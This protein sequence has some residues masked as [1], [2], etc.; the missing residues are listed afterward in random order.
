M[1]ELSDKNP[2]TST[3]SRLTPIREG[4][5]R[6]YKNARDNSPT[7]RKTT[8]TSIINQTYP[9]YPAPAATAGFLF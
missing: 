9:N 1:G 3:N 7:A 8:Y 4:Q 6:D 2:T 5:L